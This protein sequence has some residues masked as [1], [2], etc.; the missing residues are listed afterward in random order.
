MV[1]EPVEDGGGDH[2]IT[3]H[4]RVPLFPSGSCLTSRSLTRI[5]FGHR[6]EVLKERWSRLCRCRAAGRPAAGGSDR[7]R[8]ILPRQ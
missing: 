6:L 3:E 2:G 4:V 7:R 5:I 1:Q 8:R